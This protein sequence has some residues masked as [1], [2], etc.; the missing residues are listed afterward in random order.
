MNP[1]VTPASRKVFNIKFVL[2][3]LLHACSHQPSKGFAS[4]YFTKRPLAHSYR[5]A[6]FIK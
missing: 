6:L 3:K 1:G 2:D 4:S 5:S